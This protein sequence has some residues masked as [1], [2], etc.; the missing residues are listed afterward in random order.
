MKYIKAKKPAE[1]RQKLKLSTF[2][3]GLNLKK[4][5]NLMPISSAFCTYNFSHADGALTGGLGITDFSTHFFKGE[6]VFSEAQSAI[7]AL[8]SIEMVYHAKRFSHSQNA[9]QDK[10]LM[11]TEDKKLYCLPLNTAEIDANSCGVEMVPNLIFKEK[12]VAINYRLDGTDCTILSSPKDNMV[13]LGLVDGI[14][15]VADAPHISSMAIH[16]ERLFATV[17]GEQ[18]SIWFSD[19]LDPTNW[20]VSLTEAGFIEMHDERGA[21]KKVVSFNDYIYIFRDYGITRLS[22]FADQSTFSVAQLFV[23]S[24]KIYPQTVVL[25]GDVVVFL[26]SD[27]LYR[28]D[29][30]NCTKILSN[31]DKG[32]IGKDNSNAVAGYFENKYYLSC[33]FEFFDKV[34]AGEGLAKNNCLI[35][36]DLNTMKAIFMRGAEIIDISTVLTDEFNGV[37]VCAKKLGDNKFKMGIIDHSGKIFEEPTEKVWLSPLTDLGYPSRRKCIRA[38]TINSSCD[39]LVKFKNERGKTLTKRIIGGVSPCVIGLRF[40]GVKFSFEFLTKSADSVISNP[41]LTISMNEGV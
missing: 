41:N 26:A 12:P 16:Y 30:V 35:E 4:S 3:S 2:E 38:L 10:L 29:G 36:V 27:G 31:L 18:S 24:G 13:V 7:E 19:D 14:V 39:A 17:D 11:L 22:A 20:S 1:Y 23:A 6:R 40:F 21:L 28:F 32:F 25:C 5:E 33:G 37:V 34:V 9:R 15:K 8:P